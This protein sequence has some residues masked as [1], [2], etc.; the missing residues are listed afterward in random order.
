MPSSNELIIASFGNATLYV[1]KDDIESLR[2]RQLVVDA[3]HGNGGLFS[4]ERRLGVRFF[5]RLRKVPNI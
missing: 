3:G 1:R 4:M 2:Q 5:T